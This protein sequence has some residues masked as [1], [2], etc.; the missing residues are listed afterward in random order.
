MDS[1]SSK[2]TKTKGVTFQQVELVM[3]R[4]K[5]VIDG[6]AVDIY[7]LR[8]ML[9]F[10]EFRLFRYHYLGSLDPTKLAL[11]QRV[12]LARVRQLDLFCENIC[13]PQ[14]P[15]RHRNLNKTLVSHGGGGSFSPARQM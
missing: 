9:N 11:L 14:A 10:G 12:I 8:Y 13:P 15:A 3:S 2:Q 7:D 1:T 6:S 4:A 5:S